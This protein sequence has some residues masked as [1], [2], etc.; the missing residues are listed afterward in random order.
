MP[1][2]LP[3]GSG[4]APELSLD[5]ANLVVENAADSIFVMDTEGRTVFANPAAE[6]TFGWSQAEMRGKVLHDMLH[7]HYPDGRPFPMSEC[8]LGDVFLRHQTLD[9]HE[10]V[11]FHRDGSMV[12]VA[13]SNAPVLQGDEMIG[14]VLIAV[15]ITERK[16]IERK[17]AAALAAKEA[18]IKEVHHRVKNSLMMVV[19]LLQ[20]QGH[21]V[22]DP[23]IRSHFDEAGRRVTAVAR[24]HERLYRIED[25]E[26]VDFGEFLGELCKESLAAGSDA[27]RI[28]L[29][30]NIQPMVLPTDTALPLA[31]LANELVTNALK[32][33]FPGNRTG[34]VAVRFAPTEKGWLL[35][36]A[37]DGIGLPEGFERTSLRSLG[38]RL[39]KTLAGQVGAVLEIER[40][41]GTVFTLR[42]AMP[43]A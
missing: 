27:D 5:L 7:H 24:M 12:H 8:P 38:M 31:L 1:I 4:E 28:A 40:T 22:A 41:T 36:V 25:V 21:Q 13:C 42:G 16:L 10:D 39:V 23:E 3:L 29:D 20:L 32:H 30:L 26:S 43:P 11:F 14:A 15:D 19:G 2:Y 37:D 34:R 17:L 35:Q 9:K 18:L 33:A 6:R